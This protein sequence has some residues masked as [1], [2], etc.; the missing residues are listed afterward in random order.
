M[1]VFFGT[2]MLKG[3]YTYGSYLEKILQNTTNTK[4][5]HS[6]IPQKSTPFNK[7]IDLH[8]LISYKYIYNFQ[9]ILSL[10]INIITI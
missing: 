7:I 2:P 5:F 8:I 10:N 1:A 9:Q 3:W 4:N 6:K